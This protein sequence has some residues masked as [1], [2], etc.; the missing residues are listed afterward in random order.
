MEYLLDRG[1]GGIAF[2]MNEGWSGRNMVLELMEETCRMV[3]RRRRPDVEPLVFARAV[4]VNAEVLLHEG[5]TGVFCCDDVSAIQ[6]MGRL[7][8]QGV[9]VPGQ[10]RLASYGNTDL[11]RYFTPAITSVDPHND[12]MVSRL[13]EILTD[14]EEVPGQ[15][16]QHVVQPDLVIRET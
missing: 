14:G 12:E 7:T 13:V 1:N 3:L 8:E 5:I 11:A 15:V 6:V 4:D 9:S 10:M 16:R 2:V